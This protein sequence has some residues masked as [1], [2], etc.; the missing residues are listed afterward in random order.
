MAMAR[1]SAPPPPAAEWWRAGCFAAAVALPM[2]VWQTLF[3]VAALAFLVLMSFWSVESF[4]LIP[5]FSLANWIKMYGAGYFR[6][7]YVRTCLYASLASAISSLIAFP[8]A[9]GLA[10]EVSPAMRRLA[11]SS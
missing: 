1:K 6:D 5:D 7:T 4:R 3:F 10:F 11:V 2:P 9:Y 8:C